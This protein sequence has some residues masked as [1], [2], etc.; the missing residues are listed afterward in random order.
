MK[1]VITTTKFDLSKFIAAINDFW[2]DTEAAFPLVASG[3][4]DFGTSCLEEPDAV[5]NTPLEWLQH[6]QTLFAQFTRGDGSNYEL[7]DGSELEVTDD[8][9]AEGV[10]YDDCS[11][12]GFLISLNESLLT[13]QTAVLRDISGEC[14][15]EAVEHA[16]VFEGPMKT[17]VQSLCR[18]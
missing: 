1:T 11:T 7:A 3:F 18:S 6:T 17:F 2:G 15:V 9:E 12:Y 8:D 13:I 14:V 5:G 10:F 16:G 4:A